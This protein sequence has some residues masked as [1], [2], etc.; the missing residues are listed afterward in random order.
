MPLKKATINKIREL[1]EI[2]FE[3]KIF[4]LDIDSEVVKKGYPW[5][6]IFFT[7]E[8]AIAALKERSLIT[9]IGQSF[10]PQLA[11][12]V[13]EDKYKDVYLN[14]SLVC[15]LDRGVVQKIDLICREL[16]GER[17]GKKRIPNHK[18]E[19]EEIKKARNGKTVNTRIVL[20]LYVGDYKSGPLYYEIKSPKPNLDQTEAAKKKILQFMSLSPSHHGF[21]ALHYNPYITKERYNWRFTKSIMDMEKQVLIGEEMWNYLG[22]KNTYGEIIKTLSEVSKEKWKQFNRK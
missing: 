20:D 17:K 8:A 9:S 15:R 7:P 6:S 13:A 19:M 16:R 5:H 14:Y 18:M 3:D 2:F 22:D 21:Y 11:K 4:S 12:I 1:T 10:V